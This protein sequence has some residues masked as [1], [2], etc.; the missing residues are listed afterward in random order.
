[1]SILMVARQF[2]YAN[3]IISQDFSEPSYLLRQIMNDLTVSL[4]LSLDAALLCVCMHYKLCGDSDGGK[5]P[6]ASNCK[7]LPQ[8]KCRNWMRKVGTELSP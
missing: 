2:C 6:R 3:K 4:A 7:I 1:M 5:T 8:Q